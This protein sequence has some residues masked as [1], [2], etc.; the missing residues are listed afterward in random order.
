[1]CGI[2]AIVPKADIRL[3]PSACRRALSTLSWRGPDHT[4]SEVWKDRVLGELV[5]Q[6]GVLKYIGKLLW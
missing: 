3:D 6:S 5:Q 4:V 1:M 2:L